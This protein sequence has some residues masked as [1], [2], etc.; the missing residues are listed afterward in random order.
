MCFGTAIPK[1]ESWRTSQTCPVFQ[2]NDYSD[3]SIP[4]EQTVFMGR[5]RVGTIGTSV[6]T[7]SVTLRHHLPCFAQSGYRA[8]ERVAADRVKAT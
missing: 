2:G 4:A 5:T 3:F 1:F 8:T 7:R 6:R